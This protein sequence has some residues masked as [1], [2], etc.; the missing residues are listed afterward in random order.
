MKGTNEFEAVEEY[1]EE[2]V[3]VSYVECLVLNSP[4][5]LFTS[6]AFE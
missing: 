4:P 6:S 1:K 3:K 2:G 5:P